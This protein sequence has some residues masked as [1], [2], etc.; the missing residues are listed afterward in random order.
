MMTLLAII[1]GMV[2]TAFVLVIVA[3]LLSI[4]GLLAGLAGWII[5]AVVFI[6]CCVAIF[7]F[8]KWLFRDDLDKK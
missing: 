7:R 8:A 3:I 2:V 4:F 6:V 1:G 5:E